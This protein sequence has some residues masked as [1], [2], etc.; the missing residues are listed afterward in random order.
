MMCLLQFAAG[1]CS[2]WEG[3]EANEDMTDY[4]IKKPAGDFD[5]KE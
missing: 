1:G 4:F 2:L 3:M 5:V